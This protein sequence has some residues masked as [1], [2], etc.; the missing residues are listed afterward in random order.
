MAGTDLSIVVN[1]LADTKSMSK[2]LKGINGQ[3]TSWANTAKRLGAGLGIAFGASQAID[4]M[5]DAVGAASELQEAQSKLDAVYGESAQEVREWAANLDTAY[6]I[7]ERTA[8]SA[9][10]TMGQ[11]LKAMGQTAEEAAALSPRLVELAGD[12]GSFA[13]KDTVQVLGAITSALTG[14]FEALKSI[15]VVLNEALLREAALREGIIDTDR[16]LSTREKS[17]AVQAELFRQTEDAQGDAAKT[18]D[19]YAGKMRQLDARL[20]NTLTDLGGY[21]LP[22]VTDGLG[23]VLWMLDRIDEAGENLGGIIQGLI[24]INDALAGVLFGGQTVAAQIGELGGQVQRL[25]DDLL[26]LGATEDDVADVITAVAGDT[27]LERLAN[28][29]LA[30]ERWKATLE[31][32]APAVKGAADEMG[33]FAI[34]LSA[35][36]NL[37]TPS[38]FLRGVI[39]GLVKAEAEVDKFLKDPGKFQKK[40]DRIDRILGRLGNKFAQVM[41]KKEGP[42]RGRHRCLPTRYRCQGGRGPVHLHGCHKSPFR[43]RTGCADRGREGDRGRHPG[44]V[45][46]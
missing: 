1:L 40:I 36:V 13:D 24:T 26:A 29:I 19:T 28:S 11:V 41:K 3:L 32:L 35:V 15:G 2:N 14:E 23:G 6:G 31:S 9:A 46:V 38:E 17:L 12:M 42:A 7:S 5:K 22:L 45:P 4:I 39:D 43:R 30:L 20:D 37:P 44:L 25:T 18:A 21:L 10:G 16:A 33:T 34:D 8:A 27:Q